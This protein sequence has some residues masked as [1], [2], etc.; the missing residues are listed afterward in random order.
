MVNFSTSMDMNVIVLMDII[1]LMECVV[2]V[3][4]IKFLSMAN[5]E[6][7]AHVM[8]YMLDKSVIVDM[9]KLE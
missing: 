3:Q 9:I 7:D 6:I 2:S 5:V 8:K 4:V 1:K